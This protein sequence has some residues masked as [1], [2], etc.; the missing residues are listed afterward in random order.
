MVLQ[1]LFEYEFVIMELMKYINVTNLL[2]SSPKY[3]YNKKNLHYKKINREYS[4]KYYL[5]ED[6]RNTVLRSVSYPSIQLQLDLCWC[7]NIT[8]VSMLG[9]VHTLHLIKCENITDVSAL[10]NV[11]TLNLSGC[12]N[13]K[14]V[15]ALGNVHT[16]IVI[17]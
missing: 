13:I 3:K 7:D 11:H 12:N 17:I 14:D 5:N 8:D 4:L 10:G 1:D 9:N 6:Y 2:N 16:F 15:S